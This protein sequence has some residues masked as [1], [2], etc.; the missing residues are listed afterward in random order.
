L[1]VLAAVEMGDQS[2]EGGGFKFQALLLG[3][4]GLFETASS[5]K[6]Q[7]ARLNGGGL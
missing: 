1:H 3:H 6:L 7:A 4:K 5:G 2:A